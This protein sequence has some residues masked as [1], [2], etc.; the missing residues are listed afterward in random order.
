MSRNLAVKRDYI[1][2]SICTLALTYFGHLLIQ[3]LKTSNA[4]FTLH[5]LWVVMLVTLCI[6][7]TLFAY[8]V[9]RYGRI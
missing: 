4:D 6:K 2:I 3:E 9:F 7:Y 1:A 5:V 8:W